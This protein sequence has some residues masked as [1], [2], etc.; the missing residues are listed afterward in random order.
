MLNDVESAAP[1]HVIIWFLFSFQLPVRR[2][3]LLAVQ[4]GQLRLDSL[5]LQ[6]IEESLQLWDGPR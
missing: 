2:S 3:Q 6:L 1:V 4:L 5:T